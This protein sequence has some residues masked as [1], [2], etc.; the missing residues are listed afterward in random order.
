M[1]YNDNLIEFLCD[2]LLVAKKDFTAEELNL[3]DDLVIDFYDYEYHITT[4]MDLNVLS[5]FHNLESLRLNFVYVSETDN[6]YFAYLPLEKLVFNNSIVE[7]IS[8]IDNYLLK[9]LG[10][11][12]SK[13]SD[14]NFV[15]KQIHLK[16]L[17]LIDITLEN[18]DFLNDLNEIEYLSLTGSK[19]DNFDSI[20]NLTNLKTID[21]DDSNIIDFSFLKYLPSLKCVSISGRQFRNN[22]SIFKELIHK[23]IKV[24]NRHSFIY[25]KEDVDND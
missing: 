11:I 24:T 5:D 12:K 20:N 10:I 25:T 18:L 9:T 3:V 6:K 22:K 13:I 2:K 15:S 21:L 14:Y 16:K 8:F 23:G 7:E 17:Y 4:P 19:I 1:K